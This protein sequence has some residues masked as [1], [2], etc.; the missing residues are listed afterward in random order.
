MERQWTDAER[1]YKAD[2]IYE[3]RCRIG[4]GEPFWTIGRCCHGTGG[5]APGW[6]KVIGETRAFVYGDWSPGYLCRVIE[7]GAFI[8]DTAP[9]GA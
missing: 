4:D 3:V 9:V 7:V 6:F 1:K 5:D 2:G 8:I